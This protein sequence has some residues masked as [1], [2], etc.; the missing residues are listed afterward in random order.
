MVIKAYLNKIK[1]KF[2]DGESTFYFFVSIENFIGSDKDFCN[3]LLYNH[4]IAVVPGSAYGISTNRYIRISFGTESTVRIKN[5][6][7]KIKRVINIKNIN[8]GLLE[9][10]IKIWNI[11]FEKKKIMKLIKN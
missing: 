3:Y 1:L 7:D 8:K 11:W 6:L 2:L 9:K 4:K 10:K 5:A